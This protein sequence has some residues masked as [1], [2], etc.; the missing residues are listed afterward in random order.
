MKRAHLT[1]LAL[2]AALLVAGGA[3]YV[4]RTTGRTSESP[5]APSSAP[6]GTDGRKVLYWHDP[7]VPGPRFDKPGKSPSM[8]T[9]LSSL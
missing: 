3:F 5:V 4:G 6:T 9:P 2:L 1:A 7:M 8:R